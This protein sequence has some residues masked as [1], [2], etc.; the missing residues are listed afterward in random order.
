M[1][2]LTEQDRKQ[3]KAQHKEE[4]DKRICD[5]IKAILLYDEC[6]TPQQIAK[7]LLI[8]DQA[9]RNHV[10]DYKSSCKL[11]PEGGGSGEKLSEQ[12]S[13]RLEAHLQERTYLY[14]KDIIAY[15]KRAFGIIYTIPGLRNWLH[16]HGFTYKKPAIVPG[17]A[18]VYK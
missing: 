2:F 7:A 13:K 15:V 14:I 12:Q 18:V 3:L 17:K 16:R 1:N 10:D 6:W 11:K 9:V 4:R 5:R 8:S